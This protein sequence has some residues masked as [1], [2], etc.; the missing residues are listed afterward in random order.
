MSHSKKKNPSQDLATMIVGDIKKLGGQTVTPKPTRVSDDDENKT[1]LV[2]ST[3]TQD[4][5]FEQDKSFETARNSEP[6]NVTRGSSKSS[7]IENQVFQASHLKISQQKILQLEKEIDTLRSENDR[8]HSAAEVAKSKVDELLSKIHQLDRAKNEIREQA[9]ID[10]SQLQDRLHNKDYEITKLKMK[11]EEL[12]KQLN[13]DFR[14]VRVKERELENRLE[15]I[16][17]EKTALV[18]S[19]DETI[20]NLK[21]KNEELQLELKTFQQKCHE[22]NQKIE[23]NHDQ[24]SRTV[25]ALRLALSNLEN[26]ENTMTV[27]V[28]APLKKVE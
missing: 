13:S 8:L 26:N 4:K 28:A 6:A 20:L 2:Q 19:K 5:P 12:E 10:Q 21:R 7:E 15:L 9:G 24:F 23:A 14:K 25:R 27:S 17:L 3:K 16:K 22:L 1:V 18:R 11:V